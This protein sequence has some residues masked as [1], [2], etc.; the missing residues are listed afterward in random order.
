[1]TNRTITGSIQFHNGQPWPNARLV[2]TLLTDTAARPAEA[3]PVWSKTYYTL[4]NGNLPA[5]VTLEVP[6]TG[7]FLYRLKI[8]ENAPIDL[9]TAFSKNTRN[10]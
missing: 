3:L 7:A 6:P 2:F 10:I 4:S 9:R 5:G 8:E 1:M